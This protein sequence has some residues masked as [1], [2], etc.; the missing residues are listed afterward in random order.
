LK[1][2]RDQ[3]GFYLPRCFNCLAEGHESR[4]CKGVRRAWGTF[5]REDVTQGKPM[6]QGPTTAFANPLA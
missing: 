1:Q 2:S 5:R 4:Q 6:P 3:H